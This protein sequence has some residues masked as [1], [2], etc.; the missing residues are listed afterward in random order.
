[1]KPGNPIIIKVLLPAKRM[2]EKEMLKEDPLE[3]EK[4]QFM[5]SNLLLSHVLCGYGRGEQGDSFH[6]GAE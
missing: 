3:Y 1:M 2:G 4:S 6:S 5:F